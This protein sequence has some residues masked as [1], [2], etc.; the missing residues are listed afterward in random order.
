MV[1]AFDLGNA[2]YT[3]LATGIVVDNM[4]I[5]GHEAAM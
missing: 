3:S 4:R 5:D 2:V 1:V